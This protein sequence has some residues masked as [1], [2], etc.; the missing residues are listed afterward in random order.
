MI[1][2][3]DQKFHGLSCFWGIDIHETQSRKPSV[4]RLPNFNTVNMARQWNQRASFSTENLFF[5]DYSFGSL[6]TDVLLD[7]FWTVSCIPMPQKQESPWNFW[8]RLKILGAHCELCVQLFGCALV[9]ES[10]QERTLIY[11]FGLRRETNGQINTQLNAQWTRIWI[12]IWKY[13]A[14]FELDFAIFM[15]HRC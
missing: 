2:N 4:I 1:F 8:S 11:N 10:C 3:L 7:W 12:L 5:E 14:R 13:K 15:T 6:M 9:N